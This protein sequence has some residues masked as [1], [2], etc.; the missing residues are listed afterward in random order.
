MAQPLLVIRFMAMTNSCYVTNISKS[1]LKANRLPYLQN[2][3]PTTNWIPQQTHQSTFRK[4]LS[5]YRHG[6]IWLQVSLAVPT[7]HVQN[8]TLRISRCSQPI[9]IIAIWSISA[10]WPA[11]KLRPTF[12]VCGTASGVRPQSKTKCQCFFHRRL[13]SEWVVMLRQTWLQNWRLLPKTDNDLPWSQCVVCL[14][15]PSQPLYIIC[16]PT[17]LIGQLLMIIGFIR[18]FDYL[19]DP[20]Y[21][22]M[23]R[24]IAKMKHGPNPHSCR[25]DW[26]NH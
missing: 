14:Y 6:W 16:S 26:Q 12:A 25:S 17:L 4:K 7:A 19:P 24:P 23:H 2:G 9:C 5:Y 8:K 22:T 1:F 18:A 11:I 15:R 20:N 3:I 21:Y 10:A 13:L